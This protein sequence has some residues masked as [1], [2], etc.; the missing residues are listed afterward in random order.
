MGRQGTFL[1]LPQALLCANGTC[2]FTTSSR[3]SVLSLF[4]QTGEK[5]TAP[6]KF[7]SVLG[8]SV[9]VTDAS[10]MRST[11][12]FMQFQMLNASSCS[13][14]LKKELFHMHF[15]ASIEDFAISLL[16]HRPPLQ[17]MH[18]SLGGNQ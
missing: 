10:S 7:Y 15:F 6:C 1:F 12:C 3:P 17:A 13:F 18:I 9:H 16:P 2:L 4:L 11:C 8:A 5:R 14:F